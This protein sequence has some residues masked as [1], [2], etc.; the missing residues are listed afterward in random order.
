MVRYIVVALALIASVPT[1]RVD[2]PS[3]DEHRAL[4]TTDTAFDEFNAKVREYQQLREAI[5]RDL[6]SERVIT[7]ADGIYWLRDAL[8]R[9]IR[10][11][12]LGVQEG[13][14]FTPGT[15]PIF[16]RLIAA[17]AAAYRVELEDLKRSLRHERLPMAR[18]PVV[19]EPYDWRLGAWMWPALLQELPP[20]PGDLQYRI[21][22]DDLVL[23]DIGAGL[24]VDILDDALDPEDE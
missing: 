18:T 9:S 4:R 10:K 17:T 1:A 20:L 3:V 11:A 8:Q 23:I 15:A 19:N 16:R 2:T 24:V 22:D 6:P 14:I 13:N 5:A 21:V 12:R 7:D